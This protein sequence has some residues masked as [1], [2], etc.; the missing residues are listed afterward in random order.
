M[1]TN[2]PTEG[3]GDTPADVT[4]RGSGEGSGSGEVPPFSPE[5]LVLID[6][7]IASRKGPTWC[8]WGFWHNH[9]DYR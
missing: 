6:R 9:D 5:Q 7:L 3:T 4:T 8:C 2:S 1:S